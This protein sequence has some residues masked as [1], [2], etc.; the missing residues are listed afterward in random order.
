[1]AV[2]SSKRFQRSQVYPYH[3]FTPCV[4]VIGALLW[5]VYR[6]RPR[7]LSLLV[8]AVL[9][10][11]LTPFLIYSAIMSVSEARTSPLVSVGLVLIVLGSHKVLSLVDRETMFAIR[12]SG[13]G[14]KADIYLTDDRQLANTITAYIRQALVEHRKPQLADQHKG[15]RLT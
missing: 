3:F 14:G 8:Y 9:A 4:L 6:K 15:A 11:L 1:M 12:I 7:G 2:L 13:P 10:L 5:E